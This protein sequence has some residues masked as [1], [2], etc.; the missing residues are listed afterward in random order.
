MGDILEFKRK[1]LSEELEL[2]EELRNRNHQIID[3]LN[4]ELNQ[5]SRIERLAFMVLIAFE[6]CIVQTY[7]IIILI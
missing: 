4:R 5:L 1:A 2:M 3:G 6:I 7:L